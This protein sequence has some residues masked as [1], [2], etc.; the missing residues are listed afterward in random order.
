MAVLSREEVRVKIEKGEPLRVAFR[1]ANRE[2]L[3]IVSGILA[4]L[5][6]KT[7]H[8]YLL[9]SLS[10]VL[11][12]IL[13]NAQ[14]A[15]AKRV[16]FLKNNLNINDP[17][18]YQ[19]GMKIFHEKVIGDF[20]SIE[21]DIKASEFQVMILFEK[22]QDILLIQVE[23][24]TAI[25][26]EELKRIQLRLDKARQYNDFTEA[27]A[28]VEDETEGAGLGI[29]LTVLFL[30]N[31]GIDTDQFTITT[32]GIKTTTTVIIPDELRTLDVTGRIKKD[33]I[34]EIKG[35]PTFPENILALIELC[36]HPEVSIDELTRRIMTDPALATD[37]IKLSNSAGFFPGRRIE[38]I[39]TAIMTIG[40]KNVKMLLMASNARRI[41][42][43]RYS[44]FE[45]I[46]QHCN[47]TAFYARNI[48]NQFRMKGIAEKASMA[49]LLHDLGK[50]ILLSTELDLV[51]K[52]ADTVRNRR[53]V[54]TTV[55]EEISI[56]VSHSSIGS[57]I[58]EKWNFPEYLIEAIQHHHAPLSSNQEY[59][60]I[61][62]TVYLANMLC[63]IEE[64]RYYYHY[65]EEAVLERFGL[66]DENRFREF[67]ESIKNAYHGDH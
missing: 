62:F 13:V 46:W 14:K 31:M 42:D 12:E 49:G 61:V 65:I 11:R 58:A 38:D 41:L 33:I 57:M 9:N 52:I 66:L 24:N 60:D 53:I 50:I 55:M 51:E 36:N 21:Q 35:I 6:A 15:N 17:T 10:T 27:Y 23:N 19:D 64:R 16:F 47:K 32:D 40:L 2:I 7:D 37:V 43:Q 4:K 25:L 20:D 59:R 29:V 48:A 67:H 54:T 1:F 5:L 30:K 8:L 34:N 56:G 45:E 28:E 39:S 18:T 3:M 22:K 26:P 63:G 44:S